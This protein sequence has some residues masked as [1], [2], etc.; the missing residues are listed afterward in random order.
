MSAK[1][2]RQCLIFILHVPEQEGPIEFIKQIWGY[3]Q[4]KGVSTPH[5]LRIN[6]TVEKQ[7]TSVA[8]KAVVRIYNLN[9]ESRKAL[10]QRNVY[11]YKTSQIR[12]LQIEAGYVDDRGAI[13][14][15][16]IE[17]V[18]NKREG[19]NWI[20]EI[21]ASSALAQ[22]MYN[23]YDKSWQ[24][25]NGTSALVILDELFNIGGF[26]VAQY[27]SEAKALLQATKLN[28]FHASG[29]IYETIRKLASSV[30]V[31]FTTNLGKTI[32]VE[33]S[34]PIDS[35]N[36]II[37]NESSGLVGS[38]M[39]DD[40]GYSFRS[41]IDQRIT[42]GQL[43][44]VESQTLEESTPGLNSL[45]TVWTMKIVGDTHED[46]WF[47]DINALYYPPQV[48]PMQNIGQQPPIQPEIVE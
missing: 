10:A 7:L 13:F 33:P 38:P 1:F 2:L 28:S 26:G 42:M 19:A 45:A 44:K 32:V 35:T 27:S 12:T 18:I 39:V 14:N 4:K 23:V 15:G 34:N 16:G 40:L 5:G 37:I 36:P 21:K 41:L 22:M 17:R 25:D 30:G 6:F 29:N 48:Q 47:M 31:T 46:D 3:N 9:R 8:D 24:N 43:V 20:T 11:I